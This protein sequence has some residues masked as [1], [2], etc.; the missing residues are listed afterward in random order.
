MSSADYERLFF[1]LMRTGAPFEHDGKLMEHI[2]V[3]NVDFNFN[4]L[5]ALI[6]VKIE[7]D[8]E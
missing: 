1:M 3:G 2:K 7:E 5:G 4:D 8:D 6:S